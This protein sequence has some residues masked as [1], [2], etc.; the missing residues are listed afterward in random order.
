MA[1]AAFR[2]RTGIGQQAIYR[3]AVQQAQSA[4]GQ[5]TDTRQRSRCGK[6]CFARQTRQ[7]DAA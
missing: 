1:H 7:N 4:D 2:G 5:H 6:Q 3:A